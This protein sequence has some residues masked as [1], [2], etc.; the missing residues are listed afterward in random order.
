MAERVESLLQQLGF[1]IEAGADVATLRAQHAALGVAVQALLQN[2]EEFKINTICEIHTRAKAL[3]PC[4]RPT[5]F[6]TPFDA[7]LRT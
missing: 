4:A 5:W 7:Y 2:V 3:P 6:I 1:S